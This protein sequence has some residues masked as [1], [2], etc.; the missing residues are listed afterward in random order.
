[1][2]LP[3]AITL[4]RIFL[5]PRKDYTTVDVSL[6]YAAAAS[7]WDVALTVKNLFDADAREPSP[8]GTPYVPI[9]NDLPLPGR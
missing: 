3:N 2:N 7:P 6:R 4:G 9:P 5:V 8:Y 1:M